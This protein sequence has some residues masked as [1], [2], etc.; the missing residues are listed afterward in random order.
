MMTKIHLRGYTLERWLRLFDP[1]GAL[2]SLTRVED[3]WTATEWAI[4][5]ESKQ[6]WVARNLSPVAESL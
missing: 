2:A 5:G 3:R 4:K 6:R 1:F